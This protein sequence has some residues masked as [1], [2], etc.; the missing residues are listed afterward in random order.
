MIFGVP[1]DKNDASKGWVRI[2]I[3]A[4]EVEDNTGSKRKIGGKKSILN[5]SPAG[6]GLKDGGMLAFKFRQND[7]MVDEDG[8]DMNDN[9]WD[10]IMPSYEDEVGSQSQ[11]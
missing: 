7:A 11:A 6:A 2:D 1:V 4:H 8:L 10:V 5:A 3:P 9:D